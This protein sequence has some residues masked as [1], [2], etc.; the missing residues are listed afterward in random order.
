[1]EDLREEL[2]DLQAT[3]DLVSHAE[4]AL[5]LQQL[6]TVGVKMQKLEETGT[7]L[8]SE[9]GALI[10]S[11]ATLRTELFALKE[12]LAQAMAQQALDQELEESHFN[13][14]V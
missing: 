10:N 13:E 7:L 12:N 9:T 4:F 5:A 1:L 2:E 11:T 3:Y 6:K 8:N 14:D